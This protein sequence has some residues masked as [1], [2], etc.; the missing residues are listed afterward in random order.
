MLH[1]I[2]NGMFG[3]I[4]IDP[5]DLPAVDREFVLVQ[6]EMYLGPEGQ[7]GD[8]TKMQQEQWDAVVFNGY[9][10][11]YKHHP[12]RV[13]PNE[14]IRSPAHRYDRRYLSWWSGHRIGDGI[15]CEAIARPDNRVRRCAQW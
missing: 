1:H 14:R 7:P 2:G 3:G 13:E 4:I 9:V 6:S 8:L 10:N 12:I 11:Q 15:F 5:P